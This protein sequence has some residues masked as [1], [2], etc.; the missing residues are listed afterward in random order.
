MMRLACFVEYYLSLVGLDIDE[1]GDS[2]G[3][4]STDASQYRLVPTKLDCGLL[5]IR[6]P[7][8]CEQVQLVP[9]TNSHELLTK[10]I[11]RSH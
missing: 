7:V 8:G 10:I 3:S 2:R 4:Y 9:G 5:D 11:E 6:Q 1:I